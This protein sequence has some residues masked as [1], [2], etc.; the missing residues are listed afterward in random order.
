VVQPPVGQPIP[1]RSQILAHLVD[2]CTSRFG[3]P[4][5]IT[6]ASAAVAAAVAPA[7]AV[8]G[9]AARA[10]PP[11]FGPSL[12]LDRVV[13][14]DKEPEERLLFREVAALRGKESP[15]EL[16]QSA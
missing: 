3:P 6:P 1:L 9:A 7:S 11:A 10:A 12:R 16:R 14:L 4:A 2:A 13:L 15:L 8:A 5:L